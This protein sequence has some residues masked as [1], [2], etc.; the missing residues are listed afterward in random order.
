[1]NT[2]QLST[3]VTTGQAATEYFTSSPRSEKKVEAEAQAVK[4]DDLVI[5]LQKENKLAALSSDRVAEVASLVR[6]QILTQSKDAVAA[7]GNISSE[8]IAALV[9]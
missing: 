7:H 5:R 4:K 6:E 2:E 9:S 8:S 3:A 1:M